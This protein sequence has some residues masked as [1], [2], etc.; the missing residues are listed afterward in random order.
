M[1]WLWQRPHEFWNRH[2][3]VIATGSEVAAVRPIPRFRWSDL[4]RQRRIRRAYQS[5]RAITGISKRAHG[6]L[7]LA[8]N[9]GSG[10]AVVSTGATLSVMEDVTIANNVTL[11]GGTSSAYS[12]VAL[13]P[14]LLWFDPATELWVNAVDGN[15]ANK[16]SFA[17]IG[18]AGSFA[19]FQ[20]IYGSDLTSYLGAWGGY[21]DSGEAYSWAVIDHNNSFGVG[22]SA[23]PEPSTIAFLIIGVIFTISI[24]LRSLSWGLMHRA[25]GEGV[26]V[27]SRVGSRGSAR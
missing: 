7:V 20:T 23:V 17:Q 2:D 8:N 25:L 27:G 13:L 22:V 1:Q 19:N 11:A 12:L 9:N 4:C 21:V 18:F 6:T 15:L 16:A 24:S 5:W 26:R 14:E 3:D 10:G